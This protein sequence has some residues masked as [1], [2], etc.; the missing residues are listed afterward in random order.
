MRCNWLHPNAE[1]LP[2]FF[3][4]NLTTTNSSTN[5][6]ATTTHRRNGEKRYF[7]ASYP[8]VTASANFAAPST[9]IASRMRAP[10]LH[11]VTLI[12]NE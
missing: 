12:T 5:A 6:R 4:A 8:A 2:P 10:I 11:R 3:N 7:S 1:E 9:P